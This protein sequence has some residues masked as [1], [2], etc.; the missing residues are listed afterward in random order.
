MKMFQSISQS[1]TCCSKAQY[2]G[3]TCML[4]I[5]YILLMFVVIEIQKLDSVPIQFLIYKI[6]HEHTKT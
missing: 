1:A 4:C 5:L 2:V 3:G 6:T